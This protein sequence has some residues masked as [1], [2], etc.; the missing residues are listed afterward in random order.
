M[1]LREFWD[2]QA[3]AWGRFARSPGHDA[4]HGEFNFPAFL[5]LVP[6][7]GRATLD[8][9][10]GEGRVGAELGRRG[11]RV[12]G[13][14]SSPQMVAFASEHH[15]AHVADA[16]A[17]PFEDGSFDLAIAYMSLMNF[18]DPEGAAREIA[19]V[20]EPGGRLCAALIHPLDGAGRFEGDSFVITGSY[21]EPEPKLWES[22]RDGIQVTFYDR[23]LPL[24][25]LARGLEEAGLLI[26]A[27]REPRP[28]DEFVHK[29]P[30]SAR[31]LR[32]PLFLHFRAVKP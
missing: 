10:C 6:P 15:E 28:G 3:E 24:E 19:R 32:I 20:L 23:A 14:D 30:I 29:H 27:V 16:A 18:D 4:Y 21:F 2:D 26:E 5:E 31:R 25:R 9:G 17:L 12:V 22:D 13:V 7:P 8:V 11:H 1:S